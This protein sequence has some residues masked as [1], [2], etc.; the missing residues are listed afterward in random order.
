MG[1]SSPCLPLLKKIIS[2]LLLSVL[3]LRY[4]LAEALMSAN[5]IIPPLCYI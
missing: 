4:L 1:V 5:K 2:Y 3:G